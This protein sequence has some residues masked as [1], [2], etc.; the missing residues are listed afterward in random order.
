M[1]HAQRRLLFLF[2]GESR[3]H[4]APKRQCSCDDSL[5]LKKLDLNRV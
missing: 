3:R 4:G 2:D 1:Q 5:R